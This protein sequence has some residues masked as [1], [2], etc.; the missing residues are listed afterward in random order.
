[1]LDIFLAV[2]AQAQSVGSF[3][4]GETSLA[5]V[6]QYLTNAEEAG[7]IEFQ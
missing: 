3:Y 7:A 1:M 6:E 4:Y 2:S 5:K